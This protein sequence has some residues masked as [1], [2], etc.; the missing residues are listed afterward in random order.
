VIEGPLIKRGIRGLVTELAGS[1][2]AG[3]YVIGILG[4]L[5]I[6]PVAAVAV[7]GCPLENAIFMTGCARLGGMDADSFK[8]LVVIERASVERG[9][10][11]PVAYL[12]GRWK[13][14]LG[15]VRILCFLIVLLVAGITI[16]NRPFECLALMTAVA[17]HCPMGRIQGKVRPRSMVPLNRRPSRRPVAVF[18]L[19]AQP[20]PIAIVLATDPVTIVAS[21]R[22][23][24]DRSFQM[25]GSAGHRQVPAL[26]GESRDL[27]ETP[28]CVRPPRGRSMAGRA[29]FF[30]RSLMRIGMTGLAVG[31]QRH[32]RPRRV[33]SLARPSRGRVLSLQGETGLFL[34]VERVFFE[35]PE[36]DIEAL[37][38]NVADLAVAGDFPMDAFF[39][40]DA[41]GDGLVTAQTFVGA[42]GFGRGVALLAMDRTLELG[43]S[44]GEGTG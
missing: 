6:G 36:I 30:H 39:R 12:A 21:L 23:A 14:G 19:I 44:R 3:R 24:F 11:R 22:R 41:S 31:L 38:F 34:M 1:R 7:A 8:G 27:M 16:R 43:M 25:T 28:R 40:G 15:V 37:M 4:L 18:T 17:A 29:A 26:E 13:T 10:G 20:R 33:A 35:R 2:E 32:E 5:V 42:Y 9:V